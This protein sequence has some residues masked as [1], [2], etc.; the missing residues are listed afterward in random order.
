M[1]KHEEILWILDRPY[2]E[3]EELQRKYPNRKEYLPHIYTYEEE[4]YKQRIDFAHSL[5]LKC[6]SVGWCKL[7]L[8]RP[9]AGNILGKIEDFCQQRAWFARGYYSCRYDGFESDW[10]E[11]HAPSVR[12]VSKG[13]TPYAIYAYKNQ[14]SLFCLVGRIAYPL[15]FPKNSKMFVLKTT[16]KE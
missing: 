6:D 11:I 15:L 7:N 2:A 16:S 10:Y 1:N 4:K 14:K 13:G 12:E 9:D 8:D 3:V 5:G